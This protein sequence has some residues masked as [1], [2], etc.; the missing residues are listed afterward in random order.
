V[1]PAGRP[2]LSRMATTR[3]SI[4]SWMTSAETV[5]LHAR[6]HYRI[7]LKQSGRDCSRPD[8]YDARFTSDRADTKLFIS[9]HRWSATDL[10]GMGLH[11]G[12]RYAGPTLIDPSRA[13]SRIG[14]RG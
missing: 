14:K 5:G 10:F 7:T 11:G 6:D 3:T 2:L 12:K 13:V 9:P 1:D 8:L 4:L